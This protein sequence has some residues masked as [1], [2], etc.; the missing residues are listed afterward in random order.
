MFGVHRVVGSHPTKPTVLLLIVLTLLC[1]VTIVCGS[2][3]RP[4]GD[5][6]GFDSGP[7]PV[8]SV[9]LDPSQ[10]E[11]EVTQSQ[12][13]EAEFQGTVLVDQ[14]EYLSSDIT[15]TATVNTGWPLTLSPQSAQI[16]GP[17]SLDFTVTVQVPPATSSLRTGNV[18]VTASVKAP[19]LAP[20]LATAS[21]IVTVSQYFKLRLEIEEPMVSLERGEEDETEVLIYNDGNGQDTFSIDM[22]TVPEGIRVS[23]DQS[24]MTVQQDEHETV[25]LRVKVEE[26]AQGGM[27]TIVVRA[28][29]MESQ[30]LY[31]KTYPIN[32]RV[33]TLTSDMSSG[34][35]IAY[36]GLGVITAAAAVIGVRRFRARSRDTGQKEPQD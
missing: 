3:P 30:G 34:D 17:G 7:V 12:L 23:L 1:P 20:V 16:T 21:A 35:V 28:R 33:E 8:A 19:M 5:E 11:A 31:S 25:V 27:H 10:V 14:P 36:V 4:T 26:G 24:Q 2:P 15:L 32:V 6:P 22:E 9:S 13:G 18:I 29:S